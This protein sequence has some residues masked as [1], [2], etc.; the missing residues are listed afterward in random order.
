MKKWIL[1]S[2]AALCLFSL[3]FAQESKSCCKTEKT[4]CAA[5]KC[6]AKKDCCQ[7]C[8]CPKCCKEITCCKGSKCL[9]KGENQ[10]SEILL[11]YH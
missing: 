2:V 9:K 4:C 11:R 1:V 3:A 6:C 10:A 7:P 5:V 8:E